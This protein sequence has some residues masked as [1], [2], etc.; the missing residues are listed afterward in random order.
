MEE[1]D[2][3]NNSNDSCSLQINVQIAYTVASSI[4]V[5]VSSVLLVAVIAAKAFKSFLQ[6]LFIFIVVTTLVHDV[7]RVA[8]IYHKPEYGDRDGPCLFL[9]MA[10]MWMHWCLYLFLTAGVIY[11]LVIVCIQSRE[12]S[13]AVSKIRSSK[14]LRTR[15]WK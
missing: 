4:G 5:F 3:S 2:C 10:N 9:A 14:L 7:F 1:D 15:G 11:L 12:S 13:T 8:S 6:R